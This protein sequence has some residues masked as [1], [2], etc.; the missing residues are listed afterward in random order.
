[1]RLLIDQ[2]LSGGTAALLRNLGHDAVSAFEVGL[3]RSP[4]SMLIEFALQESRV[5]ATLDSDHHQIIAIGSLS[6]PSVILLRER[7]PTARTACD[8]I[9]QVCSLYE[10]Q[11]LAGC[12]LTCTTKSVRLRKIPLGRP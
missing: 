4:D 5:I 3:N 9:H 8:L 11:L 6:R 2:D 7:S 12:L 1:M 10:E